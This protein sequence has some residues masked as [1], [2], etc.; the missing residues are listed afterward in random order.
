MDDQGMDGCCP[1]PRMDSMLECLFREEIEA[2]STSLDPKK[3]HTHMKQDVFFMITHDLDHVDRT[4][5]DINKYDWDWE[6]VK[7]CIVRCSPCHK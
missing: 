7:K 3:Y 5:K 2:L 4:F 6:E 1:G